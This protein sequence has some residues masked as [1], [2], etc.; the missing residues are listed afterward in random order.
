[1][2][3]ILLDTNAILWWFSDDPRLGSRAARAISLETNE[4]YISEISLFE[5]A[6][7][8]SLGKLEPIEGFF[9][10]VAEFTPN[11][12]SMSDEV[13]VTYQNLPLLH[14]D[15]F[16]RMLI[17]QAQVDDLLIL[18]SDY[19]FRNYDVAVLDLRV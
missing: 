4:L 12:L 3:R 18:T 1:M 14:P 6:I 15:P 2:A 7:K 5:V 11:R 19:A 13:L 10:K 9:G 17:A 8:V 16:D